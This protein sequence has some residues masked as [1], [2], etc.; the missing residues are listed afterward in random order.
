MIERILPE[1]AV[2]IESRRDYVN[3]SLF[4]EE[5]SSLVHAADKR[6]REFTTARVCAHHALQKL[7]RPS[8]AIATGAYGEPRWPRGIV[9]S[10][11]HCQGYR[12]AVVARATEILSLGIDAEPNEP[13]PTGVLA[14]VASVQERNDAR[15]LTSTLPTVCWDRLIFSAKEALYKAVFPITRRTSGF[16][17]SVLILEPAEGTFCARSSSIQLAG[18]HRYMEMRGRWLVCDGLILT[19]VALALDHPISHMRAA[20]EQGHTRM[21]AGT[22]WRAT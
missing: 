9:G 18:G 2:A 5:R 11:T 15:E 7:G 20:H 16:R 13:L 10:I 6:C 4:P 12:A 19:T 17:D 3:A 1:S 8:Q 14:A 21:D 22:G